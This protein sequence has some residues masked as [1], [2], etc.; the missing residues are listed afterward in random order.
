LKDTDFV[1]QRE[2][3]QLERSSAPK[4]GG[5]EEMSAVNECPNGNRTMSGNPQFINLI[6]IHEMHTWCYSDFLG[7]A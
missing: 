6:G 7:G 2:N 5:N 4:R 1:A 3:L